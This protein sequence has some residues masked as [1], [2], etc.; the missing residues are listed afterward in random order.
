[1]NKDDSIW[2]A[3]IT[4]NTQS[5]TGN[6]LDLYITNNYFDFFTT[7]AVEN[8]KESDTQNYFSKQK[9]TSTLNKHHKKLYNRKLFINGNNIIRHIKYSS[10]STNNPSGSRLLKI[11]SAAIYNSKK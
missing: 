4:W 10:L 3:G 2:K 6:A 9:R 7:P 8:K 11:K 1:M 5:L